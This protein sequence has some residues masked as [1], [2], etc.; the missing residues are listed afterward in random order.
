MTTEY[1]ILTIISVSKDCKIIKQTNKIFSSEMIK[2]GNINN[3][4]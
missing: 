3:L 4:Q 1:N 2:E